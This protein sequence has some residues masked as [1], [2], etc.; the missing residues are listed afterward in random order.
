MGLNLELNKPIRV[1]NRDVHHLA[2]RDPVAKDFFDLGLPMVI[3]SLGDSEV[4]GLEFRM[5]VLALFI[6]RLAGIPPDSVKSMA[7][8]DIG[9]CQSFILSFLDDFGGGVNHG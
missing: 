5:K 7:M 8:Q 2:I 6:G 3:I 9:K 4:R 1:K